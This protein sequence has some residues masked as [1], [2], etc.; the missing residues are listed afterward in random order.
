MFFKHMPAELK[1]VRTVGTQAGRVYDVKGP[2]RAKLDLPTIP[3]M[4]EPQHCADAVET[5][6]QHC[7]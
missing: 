1:L 7:Q 5:L 6:R 3:S 4:S 2:V